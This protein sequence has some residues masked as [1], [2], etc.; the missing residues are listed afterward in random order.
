MKKMKISIGMPVFNGENYIIAALESLLNQTHTEFELIISD[1]GSTDKTE[2][3]CKDY[4]KKDARIIYTRHATNRG[5]LENF[6]YVLNKSSCEYFMWAAADDVWDPNWINILLDECIRTQSIVF[7]KVQQI[8]IYGKI[9]PSMT[10]NRNLSF[11][12][13]RIKRR[14]S[15]F[16]EPGILGKAN[17]IYGIYPKK[18]IST[19]NFSMLGENYIHTDMLFIYNL[20]KFVDL[21]SNYNVYLYK[22]IHNQYELSDNI[23]VNYLKKLFYKL[24][25]FIKYYDGYYKLSNWCE[26]ILIILLFP[27]ALSW[28]LIARL[29]KKIQY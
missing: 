18:I 12:G 17:S 8:D 25:Y 6:K 23:N 2:S 1:N 4:M 3:I 14:I 9:I 26:E 21:R 10:N 7:G 5:P 22:R 27:L 11:Y 16:L 15:F 28:D 29:Y 24:N 20:L 13:G 19:G